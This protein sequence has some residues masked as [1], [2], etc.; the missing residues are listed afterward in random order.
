MRYKIWRTSGVGNWTLWP[1]R[2]RRRWR[3]HSNPE[4]L[5]QA[6]PAAAKGS[7]A[8]GTDVD[9]QIRH[10]I[11]MQLYALSNYPVRQRPMS[12][13]YLATHYS[14]RIPLTSQE[15]AYS[16]ILALLGTKMILSSSRNNN[17]RKVENDDA[18]EVWLAFLL[19]DRPTK[20]DMDPRECFPFVRF[21][22]RNTPLDR[23]AIYIYRTPLQ[24]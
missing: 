6:Q 17:V 1:R 11:A 24:E 8:H 19:C 16:D 10:C 23:T 20:V 18:P 7:P 22:G 15:T 21:I 12:R 3:S 2:P 14:I 13:L 5:D 9:Y 4:E